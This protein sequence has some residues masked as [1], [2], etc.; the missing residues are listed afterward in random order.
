M[1]NH[2]FPVSN[3]NFKKVSLEDEEFFL[4]EE[5]SLYAYYKNQD[6]TF[7]LIKIKSSGKLFTF[8][9]TSEPIGSPSQMLFDLQETDLENT[10]SALGISR[11]S[12]S[13]IVNSF[14]VNPVV[15]KTSGRVEEINVENVL[16]EPTPGQ[17]FCFAF[18][19]NVTYLTSQ[20]D[21]A[22]VYP[23]GIAYP[24]TEDNPYS[25][26]PFKNGPPD[27]TFNSG[28]SKY[29][30]IDNNMWITL[31]YSGSRWIWMGSNNWY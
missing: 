3:E 16:N 13:N 30:A 27:D 23:P 9:T 20:D 17:I 29:T 22:I 28:L 24:G 21:Q 18:K 6:K 31:M 12:A 10:I 4:Y 19:T 14:R 7:I 5:N 15:S 1:R 8:I 25:L 11:W 26:S 2:V